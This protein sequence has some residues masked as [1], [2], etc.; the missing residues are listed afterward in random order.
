ME[1]S[2]HILTDDLELYEDA[3]RALQEMDKLRRKRAEAERAAHAREEHEKRARE[4]QERRERD[5]RERKSGFNAETAEQM[6]GVSLPDLLKSMA[7]LSKPQ[8]NPQWIDQLVDPSNTARSPITDIVPPKYVY[9]GPVPNY[10][11]DVGIRNVGRAAAYDVTGWVWFGKDILEPLEH[12]TR[13]DVTVA[14]EE[15]GRVKVE[16]SV[17]NEGGR[18]F[19]SHNDPYTFRIPVLLHKVADTPIEFEFTSPQA[20]PAYGE[21]NLLL[22]SGKRQG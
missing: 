6:E 4:E 3:Q 19:P 7:E 13:A 18:L 8:V 20:E 12:F 16:L 21:F 10:Y 9:E 11:L 22:A 5:A 17:R 14:G 1:M 2:L 15:H